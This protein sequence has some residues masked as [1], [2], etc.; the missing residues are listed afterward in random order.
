MSES[1]YRVV[2]TDYETSTETDITEAIDVSTREGIET[3]VDSFS[4]RI[5][6][7]GLGSIY[8]DVEDAIK[9]YFGRGRSAPTSLIMDGIVN[10]IKYESTNKGDLYVISGVN[11]LEHIM[12]NVIP[13]A[14]RATDTT[15]PN[16]ASQIIEDLIDKVNM[17]NDGLKTK[18]TN[19]GKTV[20]ATTKKIDYYEMD[21]PIY[22]HIEQLS[23]NE[24][25]GNGTYV[26]Y[27]D[28]SNNFVW[29]LRP[30]DDAGQETGTIEEGKDMLNIKLEKGIFNIINALIINCGTDVSGR[31]ITTYKINS[32]SIGKHG[33]KWKYVS[34]TNY[35]SNYIAANT[36]ATDSEVRDYARREAKGWA[37][38]AL[39]ILGAPRYKATIEVRGDSSYVKGDIW[40]IQTRDYIF[41]TGNKYY[42]LR[43]KN[44]RHNYSSKEGWITTLELE[45]DE[46]T[47]LENL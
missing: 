8:I 29:K 15:G 17:F 30:S 2:H 37:E 1:K 13:A 42:N 19:I 5:S 21:K 47:A 18:W 20:T 32:P 39:K 46:D 40:K 45:E 26:Y 36:G 38:D 7:R 28:S 33:F 35:A 44:I 22:H 24:Y 9:I 11:K 12:N 4:F 23:T 16:T 43:M 27:L 14:Y 3:T 6:G 31:K 41:N 10:S 25:T 34:K